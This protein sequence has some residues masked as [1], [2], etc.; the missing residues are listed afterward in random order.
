MSGSWLLDCCDDC[1]G[2]PC[3][4]LVP[5]I[6]SGGTASG[7]V[8]LSGT[9][10]TITASRSPTSYGASGLPT[11]L[12]VDSTTGVISGRVRSTFSGTI[13]VS[14]TNSC[15]TGFGFVTLT[16]SGT[17]PAP[18]LACDSISATMSKCGYAA[19]DG[20][21]AY[22]LTSTWSGSLIEFFDA[23]FCG[24][25][26][27]TAESDFSGSCTLDSVTCTGTGSRG[28]SMGF[29]DCFT[30]ICSPT[31]GECAFFVGCGSPL[32]FCGCSNV[33]PTV[34][35]IAGDGI[36]YPSSPSGFRRTV[37]TGTDTL[38]NEYTTTLLISNVLAALPSYP[39]TFAGTCSA[40]RDLSS[41]ELTY[42]IRRFKYKFILPTLTGYDCY[43]ITWLEG[44]TPMSYLWNGTDTETPVYGAVTEP[45]TNGT[46]GISSLV[47]SCA[48]S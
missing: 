39:G 13:T 10:Y 45:V 32:A 23:V 38:S 48:C 42:T 36:C 19:F 31:P 40:L 16:I 8:C 35:T 43:K 25:G 27:V 4:L 30:G 18:T 1:A 21:A 11:G 20:S 29:A 44:S 9:V 34:Q 28:C 26:T 14:A 22:Y 3:D 5:I 24:S 47:A 41:D 17:V 12:S 37:G 2:S 15:G 6:T 46:I 33:S 7:T